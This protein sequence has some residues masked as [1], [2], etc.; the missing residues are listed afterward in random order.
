MRPARPSCGCGGSARLASGPGAF[1]AEPSLA[2]YH[3][4][5][6]PTLSPFLILRLPMRNTSGRPSSLVLGLA[7]ILLAGCG[8]SAAPTATPTPTPSRLRPALVQVEDS[9]RARPQSGLQQA[10]LV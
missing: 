3:T 1:R 7:L 9:T 5:A 10:D 6:R 8:P 2:T 4:V